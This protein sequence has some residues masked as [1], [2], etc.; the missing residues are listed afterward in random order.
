MIAKRELSCIVDGTHRILSI[1][2]WPPRNPEVWIPTHGAM[3]ACPIFVGFGSPSPNHEVLGIDDLAAL[4]LAMLSVQLRLKK[5]F[6]KHT[7]LTTDG[8]KVHFEQIAPF[9]REI[10]LPMLSE[11]L[12]EPNSP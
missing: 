6:S 3:R 4:S 8:L 12:A 9:E 1:A 11:I 7:I 10:L 5:I 2:I